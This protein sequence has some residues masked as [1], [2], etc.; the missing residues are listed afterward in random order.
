MITALE[1]DRQLASVEMYVVEYAL[2]EKAQRR[3]LMEKKLYILVFCLME[4]R[5]S[6]GKDLFLHIGY[7]TDRFENPTISE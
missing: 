4:I 5:K 1:S 7:N 3:V 6:A 2:K